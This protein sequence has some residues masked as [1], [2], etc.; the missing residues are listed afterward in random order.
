LDTTK[1]YE[2]NDYLMG[3]RSNNTMW[4][5]LKGQ[6]DSTLGTYSIEGTQLY[7]SMQKAGLS[8]KD[9]FNFSASETALKIYNTRQKDS[10]GKQYRLDYELNLLRK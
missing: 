8:Y 2:Q 1:K 3:F 9:T 7:T 5:Y 10:S 4:I 6:L